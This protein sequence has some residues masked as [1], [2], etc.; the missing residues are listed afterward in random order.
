MLNKKFLIT[1][2]SSSNAELLKLSYN[3]IISQINHNLN[4]TIVLIINSLNSNY[5]NDVKT[6]FVDYNID[7]IETVSNGKPGT[8][9][10]SCLNY[11][12]NN[13]IY[14]YLIMFDG[15]DLVYPTFLSQIS[16]AF[17]YENNLDILSI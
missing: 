16:K 11:F 4:Y 12:H 9:H 15:D 5:I 8:G 6:E 7:I 2:L 14:D 13:K 1:I 17:D 3:S 10:N